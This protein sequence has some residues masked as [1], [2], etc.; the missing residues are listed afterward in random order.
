MGLKAQGVTQNIAIAQAFLSEENLRSAFAQFARSSVAQVIAEGRASPDY[1]RFVNGR[2]GASEDEVTLPGPILY[3]FQANLLFAANFAI[4]YL[5]ARFPVVGP[6]KGGHWRDSFVLL[7]NGSPWPLTKDIPADAEVVVV[8]TMPYARKVAVGAKGFRL[9]KGLME[10]AKQE[11]L[12][13][14]RGQ[15]DIQIRFV[16]LHDGYVLRGKRPDVAA[17]QNRRSSAFREGRATLTHRKD[18]DAGQTMKYPALVINRQV[19]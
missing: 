1:R 19:N 3:E 2:E 16:E 12:K 13:R 4:S 17:K 15:L 14:W 6:G 10:N 18:T 7:V 9:S 5:I 11:A 8:N